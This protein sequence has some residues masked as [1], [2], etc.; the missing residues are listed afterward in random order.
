MMAFQG[1]VELSTI[2]YFVHFGLLD[3]HSYEAYIRRKEDWNNRLSAVEENTENF[4]WLVSFL[5]TRRYHGV[6]DDMKIWNR[7]G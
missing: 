2:L 3:Y 4:Q 7:G 1:M 5:W 6:L